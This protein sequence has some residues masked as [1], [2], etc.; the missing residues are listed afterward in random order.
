M[1]QVAIVIGHRKSAQ[2][3]V[4]VDG[5][6]EWLWA[7]EH[8]A[9]LADALD[10]RGLSSVVILREDSAKGY[11]RLPERINA[12]RAAVALALHFNSFSDPRATGSEV[13]YWHTSSRG[14]SLALA[15]DAADDVLDL[16]DRGVKGIVPIDE[17]GRGAWVLRKTSMPCVILEPA[18]G[19]NPRDWRTLLERGGELAEAQAMA[20]KGWL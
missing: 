18:F 10:G 13:L 19:S 5:T 1:P 8:A 9:R 14:K 4:S 12:T 20:L 3:A 2:G 16:R 11:A 15:M 17:E 7:Q 6:T